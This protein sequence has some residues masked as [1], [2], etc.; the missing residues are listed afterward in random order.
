MALEL[1]GIERAMQNG[2]LRGTSF[3]DVRLAALANKANLRLSKAGAN[4]A[5]V[6]KINKLYMLQLVLRLMGA[7]TLC[8]RLT[9]AST[10][11][12]RDT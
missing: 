10:S 5:P 3:D 11:N 2:D 1:E 8:T 6:Q 7:K 12:C 9:S 4:S